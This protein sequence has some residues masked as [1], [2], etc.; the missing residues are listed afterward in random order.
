MAKDNESEKILAELRSKLNQVKGSDNRSPVRDLGNGY[1]RESKIAAAEQAEASAIRQSAAAQSEEAES[2]RT[3]LHEIAQAALGA[4]GGIPSPAPMVIAFIIIFAVVAAGAPPMVSMIAGAVAILIA[5]IKMGPSEVFKLPFIFWVLFTVWS[6]F[7]DAAQ[8]FAW[9]H[10]RY[11]ALFAFGVVYWG[12]FVKPKRLTLPSSLDELKSIIF[13]LF[14]CIFAWLAY[15]FL[16][17]ILSYLAKAGVGTELINV[18]LVMG[19]IVVMAFLLPESMILEGVKQFILML[20]LVSLVMYAYNV[21]LS[22]SLIKMPFDQGVALSADQWGAA[23]DFFNFFLTPIKDASMKFYVLFYGPACIKAISGLDQW[24]SGGDSGLVE[25]ICPAG[26][27]ELTAAE[28]AKAEKEKGPGGIQGWLDKRIAFATGQVEE[29]KEEPPGVT[30]FALEPQSTAVEHQPFTVKSKIRAV[31]LDKPLQIDLFCKGTYEK[32]ITGKLEA[33]KKATETISISSMT[34][35]VKVIPGSKI[36][37]DAKTKLEKG[38]VCLYE[39][40]EAQTYAFLLSASFEFKTVSYLKLYFATDDQITALKT[41]D[42]WFDRYG[43]TD[44]APEPKYTPGPVSMGI[45][46]EEPEPIALYPKFAPQRIFLNIP[47]QNAYQG[48]LKEIKRFFL[49]LPEGLSIEGFYGGQE[50]GVPEKITCADLPS[51]D[52]RGCSDDLKL[53]IYEIKNL[54]LG[55]KDETGIQYRVILRVDDYVSLLG[56]AAP[57]IQYIKAIVDYD[58]LLEQRSSAVTVEKSASELMKGNVGEAIA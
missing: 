54:K 14:G 40:L 9:G 2:L 53:A 48:K 24:F 1:F 46:V 42:A 20:I 28:K 18:I 7:I 37:L 19:P 30:L 32:P 6:V 12:L 33:G 49:I 17:T 31:S 4:K 26:I 23:R 44:T 52:A 8:S 21:G 57:S 41:R 36:Q 58:Y 51:D 3:G 16:P 55:A 5:A 29:T 34:D 11:T 56:Q 27:K 35:A 47:I 50:K 43:I 15:G 25:A 39:D 13:P 45:R 22:Q 10:S 38:V